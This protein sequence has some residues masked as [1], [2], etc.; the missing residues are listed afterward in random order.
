MGTWHWYW[1]QNKK[2]VGFIHTNSMAL[3][4]VVYRINLSSYE[5]ANKLFYLP[6]LQTQRQIDFPLRHLLHKVL[7]PLQSNVWFWNAEKNILT[8]VTGFIFLNSLHLLNAGIRLKMTFAFEKSHLYQRN[9]LRSKLA[10]FWNGTMYIKNLPSVH[11][12]LTLQASIIEIIER[13]ALLP[14]IASTNEY[15]FSQAMIW[16]KEW[17]HFKI[18]KYCWYFHVKK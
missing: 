7:V 4:M 17:N 1:I 12:W 11:V 18:T 13:I 15:I 10:K 6:A 5:C 3:S 14:I 9:H 16:N 8:P 2:I